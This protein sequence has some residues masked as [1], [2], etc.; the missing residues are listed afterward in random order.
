[1]AAVFADQLLQ[2]MQFVKDGPDLPELLLQAHEDGQVV[3]F[4]GAGICYPAG[5]PGFEGLVDKIYAAIGT[6]PTD[7]ERQAYSR[8][9]YDATLN[10]LEQRFPGQRVGY[11]GYCPKY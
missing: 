4:C 1:M 5:L 3:F 2:M 11:V 8:G 10:L 7:I 6:S 9:Q